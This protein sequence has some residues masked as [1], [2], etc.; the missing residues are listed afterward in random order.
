M[1]LRR[2][3][4][5]LLAFI[6]L[7]L[8]GSVASTGFFV[9]AV[10]AVNEVAKT[11]LPNVKGQAVSMNLTKLPQQSRMYASDGK[12]LI[13]S[14][15]DQNR[16][17]VAL[18]D[19]SEP[20]QKAVVA[21]EDRRFLT[22]TGIDPQGILRAFIQTYVRHG[23]TQGGST[24]TQQY[25]KNALFDQAIQNNDPIEAYHAREDTIARKLREMLIAIQLEKTHSKAEIL[26]GYLNIAQFGVRTYGVETAA[27][28]YFSKHARDLT[29]GEAATIA[30]I[31][32][33]PANYDPTVNPKNAEQQRNIV[34]DLMSKFGF[35]K[36]AD[37]EA[38]KKVPMASMLHVQN[39]P[40]GCQV[41]GNAAFF[42]DYVTRKILT[43]PVFG[44]TAQD[45]RRLLYQG[46]L[47][48]YTTL[49]LNA[50]QAAWDAVTT[51]VP[52]TDPSGIE[53]MMAA[54]QPGTGKILAM[55]QNRNYNATAS[56]DRY[57]TAINYTVGQED[58]GGTGFGVGSTFKPINFVAWMQSG[59]KITQPLRT[60][61][62][63]PIDSFP[64]ARKTHLTWSVHNSEGGT[65]NPETPLH[66]LNFSHNTTQASMGQI[67]GLC[68]VGKAANELGYRNAIQSQSDIMKVLNPTMLIGTLNTSPLSMANTYATIAAAG[69]EC[70]PIAIT[71][72]V[73]S[74]GTDQRVPSAACHQAIDKGIAETTAY[75]MN[76]NVTQGVAKV[77]QL[78][79][80]RKTF[81][82]TGTNEQLSIAS[83]GFIPQVAA[84]VITGNAEYPSSLAGKTIN[85]RTRSTW[86]GS[87][88]AM[89]TWVQF[90][91]EYTQKANIPQDNS[92]GTP[93]GKYM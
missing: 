58:G 75:A 1:T 92:Y 14:F 45:R 52:V 20:M 74:D 62:S 57:S 17:V 71:R 66:A 13:A 40:V 29:L 77:A 61:T 67:M 28:H 34:L 2:F 93:D 4:T 80:N 46:G 31:T 24:L 49:D 23:D 12:T 90:M 70:T 85:G 48:I 25:V 38:A 10:L 81:A 79:N 26:Q 69:K 19:I 44:K 15:Y 50:Q 51:Q 87:D 83:G 33:N 8:G 16:V 86:Y 72:I 59:H 43:N 18:K 65:V 55:A 88:L 37:C 7:C 64:C 6:V 82:K 39:V 56:A 41:A 54:V 9:P 27:E 78:A 53:N 47:R 22:H 3:L 21:R 42:C 84:F 68:A 5:L 35:A 73:R 91:N 89:P 32:K 36:K 30:S 76:L 11:T 60:S 63:Y